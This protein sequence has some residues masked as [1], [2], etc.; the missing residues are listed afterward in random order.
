[1][2]LDSR[3]QVLRFNNDWFY[4]LTGRQ[5]GLRKGVDFDVIWIDAFVKGAPNAIL[6]SGVLDYY[7]FSR[8]G[9]MDSISLSYAKRWT[10]P[11]GDQ[12]IAIPGQSLILKYSEILNLNLAFIR[13]NEQPATVAEV[14]RPTG[15]EPQNL[16]QQD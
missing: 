5:W 12:T 16:E 1:M 11:G 6:Y 7:F 4:L 8:D 10:E 2:N 9:G 13:L 3:W 15:R 14:G